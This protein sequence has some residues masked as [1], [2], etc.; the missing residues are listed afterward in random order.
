MAE[1]RCLVL[2][3]DGVL[4]D[5]RLLYGERAEPIKAF[6]VQD[7][8]AV[9]WFQRVGGVAVILSGK[10]ARAVETR[11]A[12]VGVQHVI[13]GSHDKL[14]DLQPLLTKLEIGLE[15]VAVVGDDL[16]DLSLMQVCGYPIAVANA[17]AEVKAV[18]R[19]VTKAAG[20]NGA[21]REAIEHL[22]RADGRWNEVVA[23][24]SAPTPAEK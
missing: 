16:P 7:G 6:H 4:T 18:A 19:Y 9:Y 15:Q 13:Q 10:T 17:T 12:E 22:L 3:V 11:A 2:D 5:G 8:L 20:G 23:H 24:Y 1:V 14:A 21:V